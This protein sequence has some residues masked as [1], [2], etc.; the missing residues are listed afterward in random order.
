MCAGGSPDT[1]L[2]TTAA[3]CIVHC[4]LCTCCFCYL[5]RADHP[6]WTSVY[7]VTLVVSSLF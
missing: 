4:L 1:M 5:D 3:G 7:D 6:L 2:D